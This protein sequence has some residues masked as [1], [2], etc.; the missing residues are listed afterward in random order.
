VHFKILEKPSVQ[1]KDEE[2]FFR[3]VKM[4]FSQRR[5]MI[6]N[7][8]RGLREDIKEKLAEAGIDSNRRPET[9][10]IEEFAQLSDMLKEN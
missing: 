10:S 5:K 6:S 4:A 9:L 7:A 2:F 8:L 1:V 3:V